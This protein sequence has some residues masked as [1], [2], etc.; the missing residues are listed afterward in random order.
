MEGWR[1]G[2]IHPSLY[3]AS[4]AGDPPASCEARPTS[5]TRLQLSLTDQPE[6]QPE[7]QAL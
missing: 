5:L 2:F 1:V 4:L 6:I 3:W 7:P